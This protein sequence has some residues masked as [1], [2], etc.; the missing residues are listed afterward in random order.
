VNGSRNGCECGAFVGAICQCQLDSAG[1]RKF[2]SP[3]GLP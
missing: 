2:D 3:T 1:R